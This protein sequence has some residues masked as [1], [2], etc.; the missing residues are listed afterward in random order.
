MTYMIYLDSQ[1]QWRWH[2]LA[3]N[4]R[5]I[6]DSGEGYYNRQDCVNAIGMVK[7]SH[8]APIYQR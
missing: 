5:K 8:A 4:N 7:G 6:A 1:G 3:G 2:L